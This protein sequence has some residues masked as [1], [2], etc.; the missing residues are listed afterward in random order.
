MAHPAEM[1]GPLVYKIERGFWNEYASSPSSSVAAR[2]NWRVYARALSGMQKEAVVGQRP[3]G[4]AWRMVSDEGPY[5]QGSDLAPFP[6]AF[7]ASGMALSL[8]SEV[9]HHAERLHVDL[10]PPRRDRQAPC[11]RGR[12]SRRDRSGRPGGK[13]LSST[14][15]RGCQKRHP[16]GDYSATSACARLAPLDFCVV[17]AEKP[18]TERACSADSR[19]WFGRE[20]R[21]AA[22]KRSPE[23]LLENS[24][25]CSCARAREQRGGEKLPP[26]WYGSAASAVK[27]FGRTRRFGTCRLVPMARRQVHVA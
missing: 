2:N 24:R 9:R 25:Q 8:L 18:E 3:S 11:E 27:G 19:L 12:V 15:R 16:P 6:L 26:V 13:R 7:F 22:P 21:T 5:L 10:E 14:S 23:S 1:P 20:E 17:L 4:P